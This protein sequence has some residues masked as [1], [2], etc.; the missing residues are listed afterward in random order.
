MLFDDHL[1]YACRRMHY[2]SYKLKQSKGNIITMA[3]E[4]QLYSDR[5]EFFGRLSGSAV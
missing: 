5:S 4:R 2:A 3:A 1:M